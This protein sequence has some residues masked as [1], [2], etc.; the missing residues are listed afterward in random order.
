MILVGQVR[1]FCALYCLSDVNFHLIMAMIILAIICNDLLKSGSNG[2]NK[3][4]YFMR[5]VDT[6]GRHAFTFNKIIIILL[7]SGLLT[8]SHHSMW[9][10]SWSNQAS[11][12]WNT[13]I[14]VMWSHNTHKIKKFRQIR[15]QFT[16][17][18]ATIS[19]GLI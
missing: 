4:K 14:D 6:F 15:S 3:K 11:P 18:N 16:F 10:F 8:P 5:Q 12:H 9:I 17:R 13:M 1:L 7:K 19:L 2:W